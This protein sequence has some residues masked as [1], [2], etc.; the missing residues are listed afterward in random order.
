MESEAKPMPSQE[1]APNVGIKPRPVAY[2]I[3]ADVWSLWLGAVYGI[4]GH[5][6]HWS[7]FFVVPLAMI[8]RAYRVE[9][10]K[11]DLAPRAC[12]LFYVAFL[13]CFANVT[14]VEPSLATRLQ[15]A[16][17]GGNAAVGPLDFAPTSIE[18]GTPEVPD[19]VDWAPILPMLILPSLLLLVWI[20][21][22]IWRRYRRVGPAPTGFYEGIRHGMIWCCWAT[23]V[24]PINDY[25][26]GR[27]IPTP[28]IIFVGILLLAVLIIRIGR[29]LWTRIGVAVPSMLSVV[30]MCLSYNRRSYGIP[31]Y[32]SDIWYGVVLVSV[33]AIAAVVISL[34]RRRLQAKQTPKLAEDPQLTEIKS[35]FV[36]T[37]TI[38]RVAEPPTFS[39][40]WWKAL[41]RRTVYGALAL[42][43]LTAYGWIF[44]GL[45]AAEQDARVMYAKL[46]AEGVPLNTDD[47]VKSFA[48][49]DDLNTADQLMPILKQFNKKYGALSKMERDIVK[50]FV[51]ASYK[52]EDEYSRTN[53]KRKA[54][55]DEL[56]D[57][58]MKLAPELDTLAGATT[59]PYFIPKKDWVDTKELLYPEL[60]YCRSVVLS[61]SG[62][63]RYYSL[64]GN[65]SA[66]VKDIK[67]AL[68][69]SEYSGQ[70]PTL[71]HMPVRIALEDITLQA[72]KDC[73]QN[74]PQGA[75][76]YIRQLE[77]R[78][79]VLFGKYLRASPYSSLS[80]VRDF[81]IFDLQGY[82]SYSTA[83][84]ED[85]DKK[86]TSKSGLPIDPIMRALV[87][88]GL[89]EYN[90][91]ISGFN[92]DGT[93]KPGVDQ[94][95]LIEEQETKIMASDSQLDIL[96][97]I[98]LELSTDEFIVADI[99]ASRTVSAL[100]LGQVVDFHNRTGK[101]PKTLA[102][103]G[104]NY[105]D[106][107]SKSSESLLYRVTDK[108]VRVWSRGENYVDDGGLLKEE[109]PDTYIPREN[110][111]DV[112]RY[113]FLQTSTNDR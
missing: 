47:F 48:V 73:I 39:N 26:G 63:A 16:F 22:S 90:A 41:A 82:M 70:T 95:A 18:V 74:D 61:L 37:S 101:W 81:N 67:T 100:A 13:L 3:A 92:R 28:P 59:K 56:K 14:G 21:S 112:F 10:T 19:P 96:S 86:T 105:P 31:I 50:G 11:I 108:D 5:V 51:K 36:P 99:H 30:V 88:R 65:R 55:Q 12:A 9:K 32:E 7:I 79:P 42:G 103:A 43:S 94:R 15:T 75:L 69:L 98:F 40:V 102:E 29:D 66:A 46:E 8:H 113:V 93:K 106:P 109:R 53:P 60:A 91:V 62:R 23:L 85:K 35:D 52:E 83:D 2:R 33:G 20:G 72:I 1:T 111:E 71:I 57:V 38:V 97:A 87:G 27:A 49:P 77:N 89:V 44:S 84:D 107:F 6:P 80:Q 25:S 34:R 76:V 54:T 64:A 4:L 110:R 68:K 104:A 24:L 58:F 45:A 17:F 78:N